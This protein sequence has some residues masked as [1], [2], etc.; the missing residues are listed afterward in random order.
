MKDRALKPVFEFRT[1]FP[2]VVLSDNK[3]N[4]QGWNTN[5]SK[6]VGYFGAGVGGTIIGF[7]ATKRS[8]KASVGAK[9]YS[10][11][12]AGIPPAPPL[13]ESAHA[14]LSAT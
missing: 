12:L 9:A 14:R 2:E 3:A 4:L 10:R 6:Q 1:V 5:Q 7:G 13:R 11:Y 8:Y